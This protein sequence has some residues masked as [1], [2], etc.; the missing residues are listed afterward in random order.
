[1][2][3]PRSLLTEFHTSHLQEKIFRNM[4]LCKIARSDCI[5]NVESKNKTCWIHSLHLLKIQNWI[6]NP[7]TLL[8]IN[9]IYTKNTISKCTNGKKVTDTMIK[10]NVDIFDKL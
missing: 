8:D 9:T 10:T 1:M 5:L 2:A 4:K 6:K 3:V 7:M